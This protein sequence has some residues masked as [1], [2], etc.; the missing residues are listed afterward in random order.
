MLMTGNK[1]KLTTTVT[2]N[3]SDMNKILENESQINK[4]E[5][6]NKL[7]KSEKTKKIQEY[8]K[9]LVNKYKLNAAEEVNCRTYLMLQLDKKHFARNKDVVYNK[10]DGILESI[11][12][13]QFSNTTRK[14][15]L[16]KV[17]Q[18]VSTAKCLGPTKKNKSKTNKKSND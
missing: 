15:V 5:S 11:P 16:K 4:K 10:D 12:L 14:F 8:I 3:I 2:S 6:W 9:L 18:H 17:N 13:L 7:D 1:N